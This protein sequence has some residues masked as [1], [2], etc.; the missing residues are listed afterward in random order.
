[1]SFANGSF[2][3]QFFFLVMLSSEGFGVGGCITHIDNL[4]PS[5]SSFDMLEECALD[6]AI[7]TKSIT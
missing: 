3:F 6:D 5:L 2:N 4:L 1:M 7:K